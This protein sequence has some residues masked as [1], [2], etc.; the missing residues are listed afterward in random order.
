M[1]DI[2]E[3]VRTADGALRFFKPAF[4]KS[5][6]IR[7]LETATRIAEQ[8]LSGKIRI[9][10]VDGI[11]V[12][13]DL[14]NIIGLLFDLIPSIGQDLQGPILRDDQEKHAK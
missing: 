5:Q 13:Q 14:K 11:A 7:E 3:R 6:L 2:P 12:S 10:N 4:P 9:S 8:G 1:C